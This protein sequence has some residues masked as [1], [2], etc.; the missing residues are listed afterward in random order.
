M[1]DGTLLRTEYKTTHKWAWP[2]TRDLF[3]KFWDPFII[4]E[5][6]ELSA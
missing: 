4:F 2:V 3:S 6:I 1:E 5:P